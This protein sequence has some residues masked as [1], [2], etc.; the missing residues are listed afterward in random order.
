MA[1][2]ENE[3]I[4]Q[5]SASFAILKLVGTSSFFLFFF[6]VFE[7]KNTCENSSKMN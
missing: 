7:F 1:I 4:P 3:G 5:M 2:T 6:I